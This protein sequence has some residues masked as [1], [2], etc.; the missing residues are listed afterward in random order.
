MDTADAM[1]GVDTPAI[2][3][4]TIGTSMPIR[5]SSGFMRHISGAR[6]FHSGCGVTGEGA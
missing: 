5:R 2:G 6:G 4:W 3:A 1:S